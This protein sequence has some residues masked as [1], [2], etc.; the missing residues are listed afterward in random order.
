M[1]GPGIRYWEF[2]KALSLKHD[3]TL[4]IPNSVELKSD[5]FKIISH[6]N[7]SPFKTEPRFDI[8]ISQSIWPSTVNYIKKHNLK[9]IIDAYDPVLLE[10][11]EM[12]ENKSMEYQNRLNKKLWLEMALAFNVADAII[13]ASEKQK[14]LWLGSLMSFGRLTPAVYQQD[15]S[16]NKLIDIVPFGL[17]DD[18]PRKSGEGFRKKFGIKKSDKVILWGGGVWNW[19]DP[20]T[21]IRAMAEI[22]TTH[23]N[24]KLVFMAVKRPYINEGDENAKMVEA[25]I[26][27]AKELKLYDNTVY[28]NYEWVPYEDRANYYLE[29]D[30]GVSTHFEHLETRFAFRT[31]ML[32]YFWANLPIIAS[33]GD[34]FADLIEHE[35]LGR[36]VDC[37]DVEGLTKAITELI[38]NQDETANIKNNI[39]KIS[40]LYLWSEVVKPLDRIVNNLADV[41][42]DKISRNIKIARNKLYP[43]VITDYVRMNGYGALTKKI[44]KKLSITK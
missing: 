5:N 16:L 20:L 22:K 27:L 4:S 40:S 17:S 24:V 35:N 36:V 44:I 33:R 32:E 1:A 19:F 3:V 9:V 31:R 6:K 18:L 7:T 41:K 39:A 34:T 2:A 21:L 13:C 15:K 23:S 25:A 26:S 14:D 38:S 28:F 8:V 12:E 43:F 10:I 37:E 30:F 29:A 42:K 11:L